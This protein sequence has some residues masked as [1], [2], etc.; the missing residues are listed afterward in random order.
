[1]PDPFRLRSRTPG[2]PGG[3]LGIPSPDAPGEPGPGPAARA[4]ATLPSSP[5][6]P[7][8]IG[9]DQLCRLSTSRPRL[10]RGRSARPARGL[11]ASLA[12]LG[13][14]RRAISRARARRCRT[15]IAPVPGGRSISSCYRPCVPEATTCRTIIT[16]PEIECGGKYS[17]P[18]LQIWGKATGRI[19]K[20]PAKIVGL[21]ADG[22]PRYGKRRF[23]E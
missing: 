13:G 7:R 18:H 15:P 16:T 8:R 1:M 10:R 5:T 22:G 20:P 14:A 19:R 3:A 23:P 12:A 4:L 2:L 21:R 11:Q 6:G 9:R 17:T